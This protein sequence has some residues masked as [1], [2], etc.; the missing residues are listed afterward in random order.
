MSTAQKAMTN[1]ANPP[2]PAPAGTNANGEPYWI[3]N[4]QQI[5]WA[6]MQQLIWQQM[7]KQKA[8]AGNG[9]VE[10]APD[11]SKVDQLLDVIAKPDTSVEVRNPEKIQVREQADNRIETAK[12]TQSTV[13]VAAKKEEEKAKTTKAS[14][15]GDG[16]KDA[17]T[18]AVFSDVK[19]MLDFYQKNQEKAKKPNPKNADDYLVVLVERLLRMMSAST[20]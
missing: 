3:I 5:T 2:I 1:T 19:E 13:A 20:N 7:Q 4:G 9:G 15:I 8:L 6:Q 16:H 17:N 18:K 12:K 14:V 11:L 10:S